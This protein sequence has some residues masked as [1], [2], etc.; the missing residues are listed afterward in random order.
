[1]T[2]GFS[3]PRRRRSR[4]T[5]TV[6]ATIVGAGLLFAVGFALGEAMHDNPLPAGTQTLVRTLEPLPIAPAEHTVTMTVTTDAGAVTQ[7]TV[8]PASG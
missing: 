4:R 1:M 8:E 6:V 2:I 7:E 3:Q 5:V